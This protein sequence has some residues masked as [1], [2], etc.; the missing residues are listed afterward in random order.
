MDGYSRLSGSIYP[1]LTRT[2]F[3]GKNMLSKTTP[4]KKSSLRV[5]TDSYGPLLKEK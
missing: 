3:D 1:F 2:V 5:T 4:E